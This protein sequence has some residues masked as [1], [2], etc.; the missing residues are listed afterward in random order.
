MMSE[1]VL[2]AMICRLSLYGYRSET[3]RSRFVKQYKLL[4]RAETVIIQKSYS[5]ELIE[6]KIREVLDNHSKS[7]SSLS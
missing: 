7:P 4:V 5:L 3:A 1:Y 2:R 6:R